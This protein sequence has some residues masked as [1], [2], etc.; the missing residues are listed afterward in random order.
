VENVRDRTQS[1]RRGRR[2]TVWR[3]EGLAGGGDAGNIGARR[4]GAHMPADSHA[5]LRAR[6]RHEIRAQSGAL[7]T[8]RGAWTLGAGWRANDERGDPKGPRNRQEAPGLPRSRQANTPG[9]NVHARV[10]LV[11]LVDGM[12]R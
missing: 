10:D 12:A 1:V 4:F 9:I 7:T 3:G 5:T 2:V 8:R 11:I 6:N